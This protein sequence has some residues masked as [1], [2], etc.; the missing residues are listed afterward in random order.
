MTKE[1]ADAAI[2]SDALVD[3]PVGQEVAAL[4][5]VDSRI[6][7]VL[8]AESNSDVAEVERDPELM[9]SIEARIRYLDQ[10]GIWMRGGPEPPRPFDEILGVV[11][12]EYG[13]GPQ[14]TQPLQTV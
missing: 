6:E 3:V 8:A 4:P 11:R 12:L 14:G 1:I 13:L 2:A 9:A 10:R 5:G 7:P